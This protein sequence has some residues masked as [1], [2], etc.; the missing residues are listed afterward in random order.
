M[1]VRFWK[2]SLIR[3]SSKKTFSHSDCLQKFSS[4][5]Y[6][7]IIR[8]S[9]KFVG[10]FFFFFFW[11]LTRPRP[12][13]KTFSPL[14]LSPNPTMSG[15]FL[16]VDNPS[17]LSQHIVMFIQHKSPFRF[18]HLLAMNKLAVNMGTKYIYEA[19]RSTDGLLYNVKPSCLL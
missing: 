13:K 5:P 11:K 17:S 19:Q 10:V 1:Q 3:P 18:I 9:N 6:I 15:R 16:K 7:N 8:G 2:R 14:R 4:Q 12:T